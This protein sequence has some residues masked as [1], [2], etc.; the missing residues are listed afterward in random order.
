MIIDQRLDF[1]RARLL[2]DRGIDACDLSF[3]GVVRMGLERYRDLLA[4]LHPRRHFFRDSQSHSQR[5]DVNEHH[6]RCLN[7][8]IL[9]LS[10]GA[11]LDLAGERRADV[12]VTHLLLRKRSSRSRLSQLTAKVFDCL[13]G[14]VVSCVG[15][16]GAAGDG[17]GGPRSFWSVWTDT[18]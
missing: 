6:H 8:E 5:V 2:I 3:E 16:W 18:S 4:G 13:D 7:L 15:G 11:L 1:E 10:D 17:A 12:G 9:T 14:Q